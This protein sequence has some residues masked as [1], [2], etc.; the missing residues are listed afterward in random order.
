MGESDI[1]WRPRPSFRMRGFEITKIPNNIFVFGR[2]NLPKPGQGFVL[3]PSHISDVDIPSTAAVTVRDYDVGLA[4][5]SALRDNPKENRLFE[6][7]RK[8]LGPDH[9]YPIDFEWTG[10]LYRPKAF[11]AKNYEPMA[12]ALHRG[13]IMIFAAHTPTKNLILPDE[14]GIGGVWLAQKAH[15]PIVPVGVYLHEMQGETVGEIA[16]LVRQPFKRRRVDVR[17]GEPI[18][19]EPV[20]TRSIIRSYKTIYQ[21]SERVMRAIAGLLPERSRGR[22][23][24]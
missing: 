11:N 7:E 8:L 4:Y 1:G 14:P 23:K 6:F 19:L 9:F 22:W 13:R 21:Q 2:N 5:I 12:D 20:E 10:K 17:F 16:E 3:M 15:V 18:H 24:K